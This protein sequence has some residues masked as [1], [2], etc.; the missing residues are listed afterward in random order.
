MSGAPRPA[1]AGDLLRAAARRLNAAGVD[2]A[3]LDAEVLLAHVLGTERLVLLL[4][5][6]R[7]VPAD[8]AAAFDACVERRAVRE[9]VAQIVGRREFWGLDFAVGPDVLTPRPDSETVVAAA[10]DRVPGGRALRVCDLGTGSGCLLLALL[11]EWPGATGLG[12]D[13]SAAALALARRNAV[14]LGLADRVSW[15]EADWFPPAEDAAARF[16]VIVSNPPYI[17]S[18]E[19]AGLAAE[20]RDHEPRG[21]LD[22]GADGLAA[23]RRLAALVP[24]RLAAGGLCV[25]E[26]GA[27]QAAA[28]EALL[29][30]A[31]LI[32]DGVERDLA[33]VARAVAVRAG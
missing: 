32:S 6:E 15:V 13:R 20:V 10:L 29:V 19:I 9:P 17:P 30:A 11:S 7:P 1:R 3:R 22:G 31:G 27:G 5:T 21:A 14:A 2:S 28:V 16:D 8:R 12:I 18:A 4:D 24:D 26:V 25:L 23:Y 33:G